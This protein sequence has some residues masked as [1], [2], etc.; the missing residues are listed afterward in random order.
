MEFKVEDRLLQDLIGTNRFL[1]QEDFY[2]P[3]VWEVYDEYELAE[4]VDGVPYLRAG[5][6]IGSI[7]YKPQLSRE[8]HPLVE[9]PDLFL[10]FARICEQDDVLAALISWIAKNGLL[11]L[12]P[13]D[14]EDPVYQH[15]SDGGPND[16]VQATKNEAQKA[17]FALI[18]YEAALGK[19]KD[20]L[21]KIFLP[22][23]Q[24][25]RWLNDK[26]R[27]LSQ[28]AKEKGVEWGD[29]L[30]DEALRRVLVLVQG[31]LG[32]YTYPRISPTVDYMEQPLTPERLTASWGVRNLL[33]A[34]YLQF[35]WMITSSGD[36]SRCKYCGHLISHARPLLGS[37]ERKPR[38]DKAFCSE[39]CRHNDYYHNRRKPERQK[40]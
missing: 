26:R 2:W 40:K 15:R 20:K 3:F 10:D 8:Y 29:I 17:Y 4:S 12:T 7:R 36:L 23:E 14:K 37:G 5:S 39:R 28:R 13:V 9:N 16:S 6:S 18:L 31:A 19:D 34:M 27:S 30:V 1:R 24:G 38:A 33:G 25:T 32:S 22:A 11:G 35:Y 21:E